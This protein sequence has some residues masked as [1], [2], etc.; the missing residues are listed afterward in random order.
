MSTKSVGPL[1]LDEKDPCFEEACYLA[2]HYDEWIS[3]S[4]YYKRVR[5]L[6]DCKF[7]ARS[8][9]LALYYLRLLLKDDRFLS[10]TCAERNY[11]NVARSQLTDLLSYLVE[12]KEVIIYAD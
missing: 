1:V 2:D 7:P 8:L 4:V 10:Y 12:G 11:L 9:F 6:D 3:K 5:D